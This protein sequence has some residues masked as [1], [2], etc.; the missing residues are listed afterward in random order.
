MSIDVK[1]RRRGLSVLSRRNIS[2][3]SDLGSF[4]GLRGWGVSVL[5]GS[6]DQADDQEIILPPPVCVS[7]DVPQ[8][9]PWWAGRV[10]SDRELHISKENLR[11]YAAFT[12]LVC[13]LPSLDPALRWS[14]HSGR[15][16]QVLLQKN[17][18]VKPLFSQKLGLEEDDEMVLM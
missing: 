13:M 17:R 6:G 14:A 5:P 4:A 9:L 7:G 11:R 18:S 3:L 2:D 12:K 15:H 1:E 16:G 8:R 10:M